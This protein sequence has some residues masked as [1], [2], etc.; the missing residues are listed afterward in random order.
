MKTRTLFLFA[1]ACISVLFYQCNDGEDDTDQLPQSADYNTDVTVFITW[2]GIYQF[3]VNGITHVEISGN[4]FESVS[5]MTIGQS[6]INDV[7]INGTM[8][9]SKITFT[10]LQFIVH[11]PVPGGDSLEEEVN[12]SMGPVDFTETNITGNDGRIVLRM[13]DDTATERGTF[14]YSLVKMK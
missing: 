11:I 8:Q 6:I 2:P 5:D 10:N 13:T 3:D 7:G 1:V 9:N 14:Q 4:S 12:L